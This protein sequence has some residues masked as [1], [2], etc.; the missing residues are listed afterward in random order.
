MKKFLLLFL[1]AVPLMAQDVEVTVTPYVSTSTVD[2]VAFDSAATTFRVPST[3]SGF[4]AGQYL[5]G[6]NIQEGT[7]ISSVNATKD[8]ITISLAT[9]DSSDGD[10]VTLNHSLFS[11]TAYGS[12]DWLGYPFRIWSKTTGGVVQ[13][14]SI[15]ISDSTDQLGNTDLVLFSAYATDEG[16]DNA[17]V[18]VTD[19]AYKTV[20]AYVSLTTAIDLG[21]VKIL[22]KDTQGIAIQRGGALYG[23]LIA[24]STPTFTSN[25]SLHVRLRFR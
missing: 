2:S 11:S 12:G 24:K 16:L 8:T 17:A 7:T 21:D 22:V 14:E 1:L 5:Y 6:P 10:L 4:A 25:Q 23:R 19:E 3:V 20:V 9:V 13:L 15:L 18:A